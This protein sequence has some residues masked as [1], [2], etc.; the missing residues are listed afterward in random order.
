MSRAQLTLCSRSE[1]ELWKKCA[2]CGN[3]FSKDPR[4][5]WPY[6]ERA[7]Y[8]SRTCTG[9]AKSVRAEETRPAMADVFWRQVHKTDNCWIWTGLL[10]KDGYGLMPYA[11][12]MLRAHKVSLELDGRPVPQGKYGCHHCDNPPC[13]RPDHLYPGTP[14]QN[15]ADMF[16]R[17]RYNRAKSA[18]LTEADII[19][20]RAASGTH[21]EIA[22]R[23]GVSRSNI[24]QIRERKTWR[25][26]P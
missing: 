24:S 11:G 5:S 9:L 16:S 10:D 4:N 19:V 12:Q 18:K 14:T 22:V 3:Q 23:F 6:W 25:H 26:I 15:V 7:K 1:R 20:I 8:C 17:G 13:V 2:H 21:E